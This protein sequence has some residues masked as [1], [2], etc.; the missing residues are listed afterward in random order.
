VFVGHSVCGLCGVT[1]VVRSVGLVWI[2]V[3]WTGVVCGLV[4]TGVDR[5]G[6]DW[7]WCALVWCGGGV[8][9]GGVVVVWMCEV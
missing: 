2:C 6:V 4:W 1:W 3:V 8:R 5:T 9:S 7:R